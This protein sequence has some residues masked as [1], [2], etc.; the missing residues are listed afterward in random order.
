MFEK[1]KATDTLA[2]ARSNRFRGWFSPRQSPD[3]AAARFHTKSYF[4]V[5]FTPGFKIQQDSNVFALGSCF[6]RGVEIFFM[7]RK[8]PVLTSDFF[9]PLSC[10]NLVQPEQEKTMPNGHWGILNKYNPHSVLMELQRALTDYPVPDEGLIELTPGEWFDP[11]A[12]N[13]KPGSFE[14]VLS[15]RKQILEVTGRIRRA[16]VVFITLGMTETW[17]D[18]KTQLSLNTPPSPIYLKALGNRFYFKNASYQEVLDCLRSILTLLKTH[19]KPELKIA[20][21]VSPVPFGAT[22]T[23]MDVVQANSYSKAT[24]L[25]ATRQVVTEFEGI[26]YFPSYEM[27][28]NTPMELAFK[29]DC[30]H[31]QTGMV[32]FVMNRFCEGYLAAPVA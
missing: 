6:A 16:D 29:E 17:Y 13:G 11:Q 12:T 32:D 18:S 23:G 31:V 27:V 25:S 7:N 14:A 19:G 30:A 8:I 5:H 9:V 3:T 26:D 20:L 28:V 21:T 10:Y 2:R 24:L 4:P 15:L 22:F 1:S